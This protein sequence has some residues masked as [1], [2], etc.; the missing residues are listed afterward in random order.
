[1]PSPSSHTLMQRSIS[2]TGTNAFAVRR[3]AAWRSND[4]ECEGEGKA[5]GVR[6]FPEHY[7]GQNACVELAVAKGGDV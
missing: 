6:L 1:M 7:L 5:E 3:E 4:M 2:E